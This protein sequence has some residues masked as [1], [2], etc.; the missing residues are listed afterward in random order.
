MRQH[1]GARDPSES[2]QVYTG[3]AIWVRKLFW[4]LLKPLRMR[5]STFC[6]LDEQA[7]AGEKKCTRPPNTQPTTWT[8]SAL[9]TRQARLLCL[10][11][12]LHV[13]DFFCILVQTFPVGVSFR[14][15][16]ASVCF[17]SR[18]SINT[19]SLFFHTL[20]TVLLTPEFPSVYAV[21]CIVLPSW[22]SWWSFLSSQLESSSLRPEPNQKS[23]ENSQASP[24]CEAVWYTLT[25]SWTQ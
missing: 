4:A 10:T 18:C 6:G 1:W 22:W 17:C 23:V 20:S 5:R 2:T 14:L 24:C 15:H 11:F 12:R 8:S 3:R 25:L 7:G 16:H 19:F 13:S 9:K 21:G